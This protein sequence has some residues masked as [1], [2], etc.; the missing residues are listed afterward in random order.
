MIPS[1]PPKVLILAE[2]A[3]TARR[4]AAALATSAEV[5]CSA[6]DVPPDTRIDVLLTDL[7]A[8][9][10]ARR[11]GLNLH[12]DREHSRAR[13][14]PG[15]IAIGSVEWA[16]LMLSVDVSER[17]L[18]LACGLVGEVTR[19]RIARDE[20]AQAQREIVELA[21]TD[22]LTGLANRRAWD[23]QLSLKWAQAQSSGQPLWLAIVDL[24]RFK[25]VNDRDGYAGG[26]WALECA[27][28]LLAGQLR[29]DD[30]I[31]RL[32]G[33]EFGV[34]LAGIG[35]RR[36]I[37]VLDRLRVAIAGHE[38]LGND[39][40][41]TASI[42]CASADNRTGSLAMFAAAEEALR[43]AKREGGNRVCASPNSR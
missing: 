25:T 26:D 37:A 31:A 22:P 43:R 2:D 16:D 35:R 38:I 12:R 9:E 28:R 15:V 42:G 29:Q 13:A 24:D 32:G 36:A 10:A 34:L 21:E 39:P 1:Q 8:G 4:W 41:L 40:P 18:R 14:S 33:D 30:V 23:R 7:S 17:E 11:S 20:I 19:L 27:A 5:W 6:A 3:Q